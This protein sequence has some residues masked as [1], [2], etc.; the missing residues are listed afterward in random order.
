MRHLQ[1]LEQ[2]ETW[3]GFGIYRMTTR[4]KSRVIAT[5]R[6]NAICYWL[7]SIFYLLLPGAR[8]T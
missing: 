1:Q 2:K 4:L 3:F 5:S 7:L 8:Y 6:I